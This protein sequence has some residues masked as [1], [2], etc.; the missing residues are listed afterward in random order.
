MLVHFLKLLIYRL[1]GCKPWSRGYVASRTH[2]IKK[3]LALNSFNLQQL[4]NHYGH[5]FDERVIEYPWVFSRLSKQKAQLLDAGSVLNFD[6]ILDQSNLKEKKITISTLAPERNCYWFKNISYVFEDFRQ[7]CFKEN[8]FDEIIC[9]ST[10]EHVGLDNDVYTAGAE[11]GIRGEALGESLTQKSGSFLQAISELKRILKPGGKIYLSMPYGRH[12]NHGWLQVFDSKMVDEI[13][14][15]FS[16]SSIL[17][18][19]FIY[20]PKGWKI[21]NRDE[22]KNALYFDKHKPISETNESLAAAEAVICIEL[23]KT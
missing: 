6:Y 16:S 17:E 2:L 18:W 1:S 13:Y 15:Q 8:H 12:V 21:S 9:L 22:A 5:G 19:I 23:T 3:E 11:S 4:P 14:S 20:T 7:S 10:L